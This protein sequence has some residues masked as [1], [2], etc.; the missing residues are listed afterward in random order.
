MG[1]KGRGIRKGRKGERKGRE[2]G[3]EGKKGNGEGC[4]M[5]FGGWTPLAG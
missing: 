5:A 1:G 2:K 3:R 4:V